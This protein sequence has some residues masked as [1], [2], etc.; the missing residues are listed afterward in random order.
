MTRKSKEDIAWDM[1]DEDLEDLS[2]GEKAAVTRA[3]NAQSSARVAKRTPKVRTG[4]IKATIGRVGVNGTK[5]CLLEAG[6]TVEDLLD[7]SAY[8]F[9]EDKEGIVAQSTGNEVDLDEPAVNG[10][11]YAITPSIDSAC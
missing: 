9:D 3:Y 1:Y 6:A 11:T 4:A 2:P 10:E 7:Q 5:T 8:D